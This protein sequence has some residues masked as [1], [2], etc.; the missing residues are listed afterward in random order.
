MML[1][2]Q[3]LSKALRRVCDEGEDS[4]QLQNILLVDDE[5]SILGAAH[6]KDEG[7]SRDEHLTY[8]SAVLASIYNEYRAAEK[9]IST[10][11]SL[12]VLVFDT[13]EAKVAVREI[14]DDAPETRVLLCVWGKPDADPRVLQKL[15]EVLKVNLQALKQVFDSGIPPKD[16]A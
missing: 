14:F 6:T 10:Q 1:R 7:G 8:S 11:G 9:S 12:R 5:G 13:E 4:S 2:A 16:E 3:E 15:V